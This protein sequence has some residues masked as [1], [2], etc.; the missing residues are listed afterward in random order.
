ME[1]AAMVIMMLQG[2]SLSVGSMS[3]IISNATWRR[4]LNALTG[5]LSPSADIPPQK[6]RQ[7]R[8]SAINQRSHF[9]SP[10]LPKLNR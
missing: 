9:I 10:G 1:L 3:R 7:P 4:Q 5:L 8:T 6:S 2:T